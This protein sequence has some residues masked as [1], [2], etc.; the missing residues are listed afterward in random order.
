M[1]I[2]IQGLG[3]M[4][5]SLALILNQVADNHVIGIDI[6]Q[7]TL[8]YAI[9]HQIISESGSDLI[10]VADRADVII[11]ATPINGIKESLK[12][13]AGITLKP[14]VIVTD[15]GSTKNEILQ[16]ANKVLV[17]TAFIGGHAMAG[18]HKSGVAE[19]NKDLYQQVPYFLIPNQVGKAYVERLKNIFKP[20]AADFTTIDVEAHDHLMAMIS[21][22]PHIAAF[23]LMNTAV[24][25][26]GSSDHFGRYVAGGFTDTTRIAASDAKLWTDILLSNRESVLENNQALI[27]ELQEI[28][29]TIADNDANKLQE[30]IQTAHDARQN[31]LSRKQH[32]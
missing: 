10:M 29:Q 5:A 26:L 12:Q 7:N 11:L 27:D 18:T 32:E 31:L 15:A 25:Q 6:N 28:N 16:V 4:G 22:V 1:N 2:V 3:E 19:A 21:D 20:L 17:N 8:D 30:M 23:A 13:L 9:K 14:Q 24:K